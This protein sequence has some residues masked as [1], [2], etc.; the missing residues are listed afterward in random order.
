[1]VSVERRVLWE[2]RHCAG[3]S[4]LQSAARIDY[5]SWRWDACGRCGTPGL[6][7]AL[8]SS[9]FGKLRSSLDGVGGWRRALEDKWASIGT[10]QGGRARGA[11]G[12]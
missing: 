4:G 12:L 9:S 1:M 5:T 3:R 7:S 11:V 8:P 6:P 10:G 2:G